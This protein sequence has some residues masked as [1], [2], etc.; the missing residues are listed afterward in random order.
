MFRILHTWNELESF[1]IEGV[2]LEEDGTLVIER[3]KKEDEGL[4]ECVAQNIEGFVKTSA[5]VTVL[6]ELDIQLNF[7][8]EKTKFYKIIRW[9]F[10]WLCP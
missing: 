8:P 6:G 1:L 3:V 4:Y 5:V 10:P 9:S 2:T 7:R